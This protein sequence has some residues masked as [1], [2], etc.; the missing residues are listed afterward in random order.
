MNQKNYSKQDR[1]VQ[2]AANPMVQVIESLV[3]EN[4]GSWQGS[5][6]NLLQICKTHSDYSLFLAADA[7]SINKYLTEIRS[8]LFEFS[9][10]HMQLLPNNQE[11]QLIQFI[12]DGT[13]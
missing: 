13:T 2:Y 10:I 8:E 7:N 1:L 9:K 6:D 4:C 5:A 12:S 3:A 11:N